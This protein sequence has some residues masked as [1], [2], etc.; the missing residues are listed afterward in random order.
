M[1]SYNQTRKKLDLNWYFTPHITADATVHYL[2]MFISLC[3]KCTRDRGNE[4][5]NLLLDCTA[6]PKVKWGRNEHWF[7]KTMSSWSIC[8]FPG[9]I[10]IPAGF[11]LPLVYEVLLVYYGIIY[12]WTGVPTVLVFQLHVCWNCSVFRVLLCIMTTRMFYLWE[13]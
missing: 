7:N 3:M 11:Y 2:Y 13:L 4:S 9:C 10:Y 6:P 5:M 12:T 8:V 1:L